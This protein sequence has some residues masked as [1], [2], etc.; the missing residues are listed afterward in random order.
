MRIVPA[1]DYSFNKATKQI[2]FSGAF[3]G[4]ETAN[5]TLVCNLTA[6]NLMIYQFNKAGY[7]GELSADVLTLDYDTTT[8]NNTDE[9]LI[10]VNVDSATS[11]LTNAELRATPVPVSGTVAV[12]GVGDATAAKQDTGNTSLATIAG[13][14]FATQ[15]TLAAL[16]AKVIAAPSTEAKQDSIITLLTTLLG[17]TDGIESLLTTLNSKD[18]ATQTTEAAILAKLIA[19]PATEAKQDTGNTSLATIAGKD[20]ATQT[21]LALIKAQTDNLDTALSGIKT[22]TDKI[23]TAPALDATLTGGSQKT[24]NRGAAKGATAAGDITSTAASADRQPMDVIL[25]DASGNVVTVGGGTQYTEDAASAGGEQ[26]TLAGAIRQD[27]LSASQSNDGDYSTLKTNAKGETYTKD[28]DVKSDTALLVTALN[29]LNASLNAA[30]QQKVSVD[31]LYIVLKRAIAA[32]ERPP[33]MSQV[34]DV[35]VVP[36]SVAMA[37]TTAS[38]LNTATNGAGALDKT[39]EYYAMNRLVWNEL[40]RQIIS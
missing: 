9:L 3:A 7:G 39:F 2:T 36:G 8:M 4:L 19:A 13:K 12:T 11:G 24:I 26:L 31:D 16:L 1:A 29:T 5:I 28:T 18:F 30:S 38:A 34:G 10:G 14:D 33:F 40:R 27:T 22:G 20:F 21:T 17:Y 37:V 23:V 25:R 6:G 32:L 35:R 15:T